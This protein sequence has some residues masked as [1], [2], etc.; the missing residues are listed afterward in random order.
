MGAVEWFTVRITAKQLAWL[1]RLCEWH[2]QDSQNEIAKE[3]SRKML[4]CLT[5]WTKKEGN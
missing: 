5:R 1:I 4:W 3:R 2:L